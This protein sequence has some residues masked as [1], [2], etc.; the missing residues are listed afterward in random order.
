MRTTVQSH[1]TPAVAAPASSTRLSPTT[2][3]RIAARTSG[4]AIARA[5]SSGPMP[6][7]SPSASAIVGTRAPLPMIDVMPAGL[8]NLSQGKH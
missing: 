8:P 6:A 5:A 7:G 2:M 1:A 4:S 3:S